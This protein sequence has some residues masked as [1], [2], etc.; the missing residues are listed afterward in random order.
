M[1]GF[2]KDTSQKL[3]WKSLASVDQLPELDKQSEAGPVL[4]FKH[5]TRCGISKMVLRKFEAD[6]REPHVNLYFVDLLA[7]R[8]VSNALADRYGVYH[9]SPQVLVIEKGVCTRH[10]AH[11]D[12]GEMSWGDES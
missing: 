9:Q 8:E 1:F 4:I 10:A 6:F 2:N 5:S 11:Y 3:A 7:H 12:I